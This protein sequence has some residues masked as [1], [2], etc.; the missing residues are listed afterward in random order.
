MGV[1]KLDLGA[2]NRIALH[3]LDILPHS[4]A[5]L[6]RPYHPLQANEAARQ[7]QAQLLM[8]RMS[9]TACSLGNSSADGASST[10]DAKPL[11]ILCG[12]FNDSPSSPA[13]QARHLATAQQC[14]RKLSHCC[15]RDCKTY[16]LV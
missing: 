10:H 6:K 3:G 4:V 15:D 2:F 9:A 12:D 14:M 16:M 1:Q 8:N 5:H 13:C 7:V 11:L